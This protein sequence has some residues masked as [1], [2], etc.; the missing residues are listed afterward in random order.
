MLADIDR[1]IG[2]ALAGI[3]QAFR[4]VLRGT[5]GGKGSQ[6]AQVDGL[7]GEPLPDLEL[8]QQFGFTSNPPS[9]TAVVVL[10]LGGRTSHGII[11]ATENGAYRIGNLKPGETAI[12]NAFG[13]RFVFRDGRIDGTT[14]AFR[15]VASEGMEF[16]TPDAKFTGAVTVKEALTGT[17]GMAISGGDGA[18]VEGSLH[19]TGD[20]SAGD[21]SLTGHTHPGDSGGMTGKPN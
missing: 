19:A 21:I 17:G 3:R 16:D 4:G 7:A 11:V 2:R 9:G 14:K 8:F 20:V 10:P 13:D 5:R 15:L 6:L 18:R 1:R 12:F